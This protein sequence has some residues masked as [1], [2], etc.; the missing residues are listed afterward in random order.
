MKDITTPIEMFKLLKDWHS[1]SVHNAENVLKIPTDGSIKV[2]ITSLTEPDSVEEIVID[3]TNKDAFFAGA[4]AVLC[5]FEDLP[6]EYAEPVSK[7]VDENT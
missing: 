7:P 2:T 1:V 3:E 5:L 6:F 4:Q